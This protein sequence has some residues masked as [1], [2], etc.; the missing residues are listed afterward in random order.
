METLVKKKHH[1][2]AVLETVSPTLIITN[3]GEKIVDAKKVF[4]FI[5][6]AIRDLNNPIVPAPSNVRVYRLKADR[7]FSELIDKIKIIPEETV[8]AFCRDYPNFLGTEKCSTF[9]RVSPETVLRVKKLSDGLHIVPY[10]I[11]EEVV[12]QA[13]FCHKFVF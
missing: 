1:F 6:L 8:V 5:N 4:N 3:R 2:I 11:N 10:N 13:R 9:F 12:W 7:P